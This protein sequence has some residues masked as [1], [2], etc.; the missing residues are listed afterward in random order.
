MLLSWLAPAVLGRRECASGS[1]V[2]RPG[3]FLRL[4][5]GLPIRRAL[6]RLRWSAGDAPDTLMR[7]R[8]DAALSVDARE[9]M[10]TGPTIVRQCFNRSTRDRSRLSEGRDHTDAG[11][12]SPFTVGAAAVDLLS[13]ISK[14]GLTMSSGIG[15][16]TVELCSP[17]ISES[18]CR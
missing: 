9:R 18:V 7:R 8:V 14:K 13:R 16:T 11:S 1:D 17:P 12:V 5:F 4:R 15:K 2:L 10:T 6:V 3:R